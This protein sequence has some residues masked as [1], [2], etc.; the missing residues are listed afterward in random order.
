MLYRMDIG[1]GRLL[2]FLEE[3]DVS[4]NT[5]VVFLS[6]NGGSM[7]NASNNLPLRGHKWTPYEGGSHVP[8]VISWPG[9][10]HGGAVKSEFVS[11]LD[12]MPTFL[13]AAGIPVPEH[14]DGTNLLPYLSGQMKKLPDRS[15]FWRE[16]V[17]GRD[18][19]WMLAPDLKKAIWF[20]KSSSRSAEP[21]PDHSSMF[22]LK[23]DPYEQNNQGENNV[24]KLN[25]LRTLYEEWAKGLEN[26]RW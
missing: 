6:D 11:A 5:M 26:P 20:G 15:L 4:E 24:E 14:L 22:D 1:V 21:I 10:L 13:D 7:N 12:L 17:L 23:E 9:S 3:Q 2:S 8:M 19:E 25:Q 16:Y 18:T